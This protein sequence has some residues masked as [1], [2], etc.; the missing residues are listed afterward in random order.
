MQECFILKQK[1]KNKN[2]FLR[3]VFV[4]DTVMP[5]RQKELTGNVFQF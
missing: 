5:S 1:R 3:A 4:D 2:F